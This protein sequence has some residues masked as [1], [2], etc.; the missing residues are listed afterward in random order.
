MLLSEFPINNVKYVRILTENIVLYTITIIL[1][2]TALLYHQFNVV[3]WIKGKYEKYIISV[4]MCD[5]TSCKSSACKE[6]EI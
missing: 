5:V 4:L 3:I 2:L 6:Y 1:Y